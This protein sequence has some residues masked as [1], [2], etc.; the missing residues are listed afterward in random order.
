[1]KNFMVLSLFC[2][3]FCAA[4]LSE[5]L[6]KPTSFSKDLYPAEILDGNYFLDIDHPS[7]FLDFNYGE[8][9]AS[10]AQISSAIVAWSKQTNRL[11][12]IEYAKSHEGRPLYALFISAP[13]NIN[14]LDAIKSNITKLS[15]ARNINDKE[16]ESIIKSIPSVAWM[17][18]SIHGN[19]TSGADAA[20]GIIYH[21]IASKDS[22]VIDML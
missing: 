16:A 12:V 20:L 19:E 11:K 21:L 5:E 7:S 15:D 6:M 2:S 14:N 22:D 17:A 10:P 13:E 8:R 3:F 9:V 4:L 1:M 18:Y